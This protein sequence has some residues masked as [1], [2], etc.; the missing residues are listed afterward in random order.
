M[1]TPIFAR[2]VTLHSLGWLT[3]ANVVGV[4]L[5]VALLWPAAGDVIAPFTWGR[6]APLHMNWHLYGWCSLPLVGALL[7]WCFEPAADAAGRDARRVLGAWSAALALGGIA[8]LAG[9]VSGKL[10][11]DWHGWTRP[12]LPLAMVWLWVLLAGHTRARWRNFTPLGRALR[13]G[14]LALLAAVPAVLF[15]SSGRAVYQPINPDSGGATGAALLGSTLGVV[16]VFMLVPEFLGVMRGRRIWPWNVALGMS[17]LV[18]AAIDRGNV[19]HHVALHVVALATLLAWIPLLPLFWTHQ[20]WPAP[21]LKWVRAAGVWWALLVGSGWL[22][23]LP[24]ISEALKFTHALVGHAHLAMAGLITSVNGAVLVTLT[25]RG[26]PRAVFWLWQ[27]GCAVYV[28]AMMLLGAGEVGHAG[29]LFRSE[30]W[31]QVLLTVRLV[32]GVAMTAASLQWL[33]REVRR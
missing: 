33:V 21:A 11:L 10:F 3:A 8:W 26:A 31:T 4:W 12:L 1:R 25:T 30:G 27:G 29:E 23:Y 15:W 14:V 5:G 17:W 2:T 22:S 16:T 6:W 32:G 7:R 13:V 20:A 28:G 24:G 9:N 18:F 19:S